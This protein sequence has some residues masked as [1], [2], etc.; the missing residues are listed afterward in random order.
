MLGE[1]FLLWFIYSFS[2]TQGKKIKIK[3]GV[4]NIPWPL[5]NYLLNQIAR[6]NLKFAWESD[7]ACKKCNFKLK[8]KKCIVISK[9]QH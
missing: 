7:F 5:S 3:A 1:H 2:P 4:Y 9:L 6:C 8:C